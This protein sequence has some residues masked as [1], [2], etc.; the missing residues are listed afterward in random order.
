VI[1]PP[2]GVQKTLQLAARKVF[3]KQWFPTVL[4]GFI[5]GSLFLSSFSIFQKLVLGASITAV[6]G[7]IVP[8]LF[9]GTSGVIIA[10]LIRREQIKN[11]ELQNERHNL[12]D[13]FENATDLIQS[14]D[15]HGNILYANRAW[16]ETLG[17]TTAELNT[18]NIFNIIHPEDRQH[19]QAAF[20]TVLDGDILHNMQTSFVSKDGKRIYVIGSVNC[21]FE[22]GKPRS[23]RGIFHN[24]TELRQA[25]EQ[26]VLADKVFQTTRE[27]IMVTDTS[28]II[29]SVNHA[30]TRITGYEEKEALGQKAS[31]LKSGQH[32]QEFYHIMWQSLKATGNWQGEIWNKRKNGEIYPEWLTINAITNERGEQVN[33]VSIFSDI[34]HRKQTEERFQYLATHDLLT[35]LPNRILF[36]ELLNSTI[37]AAERGQHHMAVL[38][39][40]LDGFKQVNDQHGHDIGDQLMQALGARFASI[41]RRADTIA[42]LGG[43][44]FG[45]ILAHIQHSADAHNV[46]QKILATICE[47]YILQSITIHI[48]AS[49]G[50]SIYP[51]HGASADT[52]L[53]HADHAMYHAKNN[54]KNRIYEHSNQ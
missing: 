21:K 52:L 30:F 47:P 28:G 44:E 13:F 26:Q 2:T 41:T 32:A 54:G 37:A 8:V 34:T 38:F 45:A 24:I 19:C 42:R 36:L 40:D 27:G 23:T 39:I 51:Q 16:R 18:L 4:W 50:I 31:L 20:A 17:Y 5:S 48:T 35:G 25:Q 15:M 7:Y 3:M 29:V 46:A 6:E 9:G 33:Y 53:T 14:V 11:D 12:S 22:A 43:D 10:V 49:I 1:Q